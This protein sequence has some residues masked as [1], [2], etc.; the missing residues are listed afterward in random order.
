MPLLWRRRSPTFQYSR[1]P[2]FFGDG[3]HLRPAKRYSNFWAW[4]WIKP[5]QNMEQI[6]IRESSIGLEVCREQEDSSRCVFPRRYCV[7]LYH[8]F[9]STIRQ[10]LRSQFHLL[11]VYRAHSLGRNL[12]PRASLVLYVLHDTE[13]LMS[14]S[15]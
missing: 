4:R 6:V 13:C 9:G 15:T 12:L 14:S 3:Q 7:G 10:S 8:E 5:G 11:V 1:K 2:D